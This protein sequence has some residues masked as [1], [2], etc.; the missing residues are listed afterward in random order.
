LANIRDS[1]KPGLW[2]QKW[3][4]YLDWKFDCQGSKVTCKLISSKV[5]IICRLQDLLSKS[6]HCRYTI[7]I[8]AVAMKWLLVQQEVGQ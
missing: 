7:Y 2:I 6:T 4:R 8:S 3:T 5:L 1:T